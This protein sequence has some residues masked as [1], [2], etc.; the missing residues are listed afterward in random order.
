MGSA[1][2]DR[3]DRP[4]RDP[5]ETAEPD[6][7]DEIGFDE[8]ALYGVVREAVEDAI[9]GVIGTLLLV[10][11]ALVVVW[12]GIGMVTRTGGSAPTVLGGL[13][14]AFGLYLGAV[15]LGVVPPIRDRF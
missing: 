14:I 11:V 8:A 15:T 2:D 13:I 4:S 9:L 6:G 3:S 10:G 1:S 12:A 7:G 5:E